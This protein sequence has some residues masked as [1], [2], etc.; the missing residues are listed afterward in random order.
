L[1]PAARYLPARRG[2]LSAGTPQKDAGSKHDVEE[3]VV[4]TN[5][6]LAVTSSKLTATGLALHEETTGIRR[7]LMFLPLF[8]GS[9][10]IVLLVAGLMI[11]G[12][13]LVDWSVVA[14]IPLG[15]LYLIPM[16]MVGRFFKP[17]QI[18]GTAALCTFL[19]EQFDQFQWN[20]R[21]GI[22]RDILYFAAFATVGVFVSE[23]SR[24]RQV[25]L[26][27]LKEIERQS[28]AR[29][30]AEEQLKVLIESSPAA[31]ITTNSDGSIL[32]ANEAAHRLLAVQ[33]GTLPGCLLQRFFPA[34]SNISRRDSSRRLLRAVMQSRGLREDGETF[35]ADISFSTYNTKS[36][37]RLAVM[38]LDASD[39]LR[40]HEETSLH[41]M[42]VGS[43]I[44][45]SAVSHEIRNVCGAISVVHQNLSRSKLLHKNKDFE[46]LGTLVVAL[47]RIAAID[48]RQYPETSTEVDLLSVLDDL[49]IVISPSLQDESILCTWDLKPGLPM[50]W[51]DQTNLMQV[52]LNL[53]TNSIRALAQTTNPR[54]LSIS[55]KSTGHSVTVE[56]LDNGGGVT[57]PEELFRPFQT[58]AQATGLGLYLS[59][60]FA[61]SFGG[62]LRYEPL[63]GKACF[64]VDLP[65]A[66]TTR[67]GI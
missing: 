54:S 15:F 31:I 44:A 58:A 38:I 65:L 28:E 32:M 11:L 1:I 45:V 42:L 2:Y 41:Q 67:E 4:F 7:S 23:T 34:L 5:V 21:I 12:I 56:F 19:A 29:E 46:A 33:N 24:S 27:Q 37:A 26:D 9:K 18:L 57:H 36:G 39:E 25:I 63:V 60:A 55:A 61:R 43:R 30:E 22:P 66:A 10:K 62:D 8:N 20:I 17:W 3:A 16:L 51:A 40:S 64:I 50:V 14:E 6:C 53:T 59:R 35:M 47:E 49:K 13:A 52:F 48:L